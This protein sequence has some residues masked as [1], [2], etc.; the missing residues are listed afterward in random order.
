MAATLVQKIISAHLGGQAVSP[1]DVVM[2]PCDVVLGNDASANGAAKV[3]AAMGVEKVFDPSKV[4]TVADHFAPAKDVASAILLQ[5]M[6]KWAKR[7]GVAFFAQGRGGIEHTV[8][9]ENGWVIP[10]SV[11][12]GGD[13]HT[14]TYGA[15]GAFGTGVGITDLAGCMA[16]GAF[17]QTVPGTIRVEFA[18]RR[19][20]FVAGKDLI[21]AVLREIGVAG[22]TGCV[23]EFAGP[24]AE[25][26][27]VEDRMAV[28]NMAVEA[29]AET[30]FF[31][32]DAVTR[33]YLEG[34]TDAPWT[35]MRSDPDAS[36][37][38]K[39]RI[40]LDRLGPL[41][42][43]PHSPGNV[44][45]VA[46]ARGAKID[47]VYIGNCAN[48]TMADLRQAAQVIRGR[49]VRDGTRMMV[50]PASQRVYR[51]ALG[52]G[53]LDLFAE[54]GASVSTPTCG[55]CFGGHNGVL[56][57]GERAI[58][59]T[60]RNFRGRMGSG[61]AEV[62]LGNAFVAAAAAVAGEIVDPRE[63]AGELEGAA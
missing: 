52:E 47:Q 36:F 53:L 15:L 41:V 21:L 57:P 18:G 8:L 14:C 31:P 20:P 16:I 7:Q 58:S 1:G 43:M 63:I 56:A 50:V 54:A 6:E 10:G 22:A 30:G 25:A 45:P 44:A 40:D 55:A 61:D 46:E 51:Q 9:I 34:R 27:S 19:R 60:N 29:G 11:I 33:A 37:D 23:L 35:E 39:V 48:G 32:A 3:M 62:F 49:K 17:W 59:N 42:S 38:R 13:S 26:L 4:V 5:S 24:G 28:S 2:L 12:A